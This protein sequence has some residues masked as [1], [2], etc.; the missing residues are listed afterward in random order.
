MGP[1]R[2]QLESCTRFDGSTVLAQPY[3]TGIHAAFLLNT[4][5]VERAVYLGTKLSVAG[6]CG[7]PCALDFWATKAKLPLI[8]TTLSDL[9]IT[10]GLRICQ[11]DRI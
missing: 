1:V 5:G 8:S 9:L 6:K 10:T 2:G 4:R 3:R 11:R 7:N